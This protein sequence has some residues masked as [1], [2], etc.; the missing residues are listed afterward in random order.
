VEEFDCSVLEGYRS[1]GRQQKLFDADPQRTKLRPGKSRHNRNPSL[2]VDVVP[3]PIDWDDL[4]RFYYFAGYVKGV[5]QGLGIGIRWGGDWSMD[6][7]FKDQTF[8][9]FT[10]YELDL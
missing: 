10:H 1:L 8:N 2:A 4:E 9:D 6:N 7:D 3:Y 5:A